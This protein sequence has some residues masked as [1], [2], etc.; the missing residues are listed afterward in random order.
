MER[1]A[2]VLL[3][4]LLGHEQREQLALRQRHMR[5]LLDRPRVVES[6]AASVVV[7]R[8]AQPIDH[9]LDVPLDRSG[10]YL[11]VLGHEPAVRV[12]VGPHPL[13]EEQHPLQGRPGHS[14]AGYLGHGVGSRKPMSY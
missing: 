12:P 6:I 14:L 8:Q 5:E 7:D 11:E 4:R 3:D 2:P 10:G 9:E 1:R 13:M